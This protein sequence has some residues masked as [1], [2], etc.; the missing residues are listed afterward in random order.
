MSEANITT[1]HKFWDAFNAHNLDG[2]DEI[3]A[4]NFIN[5]DPGLPTPEADL[6][7]IKQTIGG[8]QA[9]FPDIRSDEEDIISQGDKV[10][11]R[12]TFRGTHKG[13]FM[14]VAPSDK[15]VSFTGI[16]IAQLRGGRIEE[17]WVNFDALG[18]LQ[19]IGAIPSP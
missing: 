11:V 2:W 5:H 18:M 4:P 6:P 3:C 14:G 1:V 7:T 19:Q 9:A 13:E 8:L 15:E 12:R 10:V 17:Q 16:F